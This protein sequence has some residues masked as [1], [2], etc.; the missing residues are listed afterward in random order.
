MSIS[1]DKSELK[2][3]FKELSRKA[4]SPD[5]EL[6]YLRQAYTAEPKDLQIAYLLAQSYYKIQFYDQALN[7]IDKIYS[8]NA[9]ENFEITKAINLRKMRAYSKLYTYKLDNLSVQF[10][11]IKS[12]MIQSSFNLDKIEEI[13]NT[14]EKQLPQLKENPKVIFYNNNLSS[15]HI[16]LIQKAGD[17]DKSEEVIAVETL[18]SKFEMPEEADSKVY[19]LSTQWFERWKKFIKYDSFSSEKKLTDNNFMEE[20]DPSRE[21][22]LTPIDNLD[23]FDEAL[24]Y[25]IDPEANEQY[26]NT[27]V[28]LG[29]VENTDFMIISSFLW[30]YLYKRYGGLAIPRYSIWN[31]EFRTN[32]QIEI[33]LQKVEILL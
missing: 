20:E 16:I 15:I 4:N 24:D 31:N 13:T 1:V 18:L 19:L 14:L 25:L 9:D 10:S 30:E 12:L 6:I 5:L 8:E 29:L 32:I 28:K 33:W 27:V 21:L 22:Y 26:T 11:K 17:I 3:K 7:L 23:L 2:K